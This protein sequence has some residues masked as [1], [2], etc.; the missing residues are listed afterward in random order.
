MNGTQYIQWTVCQ[1]GYNYYLLLF[2]AARQAGS[3]IVSR[4]IRNALGED[5]KAY[6]IV[7]RC[8][9]SLVFLCLPKVSR[10]RLKCDVQSL[11]RFLDGVRYEGE[12]KFS[13]RSQPIQE[14]ELTVLVQSLYLGATKLEHRRQKLSAAERAQ[15]WVHAATSMLAKDDFA[16]KATAILII[17]AVF[18]DVPSS[19]ST[20]VRS[21]V[22]DGKSPDE[23]DCYIIATLIRSL[24]DAT[25]LQALEPIT[26]F[27]SSR[28]L[29]FDIFKQLVDAFAQTSFGRESILSFSQSTFACRICRGGQ[30]LI[31]VEVPSDDKPYSRHFMDFV[32]YW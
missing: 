25:E 12:G 1:V 15:A 32:R 10:D 5:E 6:N 24:T 26:S 23:F 11:G 30:R 31:I 18:C 4:L 14:M 20:L 8:V 29:P 27:I 9:Q 3:E 13:R 22:G 7:D 28:S 21:M 19:R 17:V 16:S 2:Q